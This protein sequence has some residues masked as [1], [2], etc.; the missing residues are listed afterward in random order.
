M[1]MLLGLIPLITSVMGV[2][3]TIAGALGSPL[4][5]SILLKAADIAERIFGT[6]DPGQIQ[7][8]IELDKVKLERFRIEL[9]EATKED[10]ALLADLQSARAQTLGLAQAQ[11]SI[12]WGAPIVSVLVTGGFFFVMAL[13]LFGFAVSFDEYVKNVLLI[14]IGV[15]SSG[16]NQTISYWLGS[17]R[18]SQGKDA[19][20]GAM[21]TTAQRETV[22]V[23]SIRSDGKMFK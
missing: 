12:A 10:V 19:L 16:F 15:L 18:G 22:P 5:G 9:E 14:L 11:S 21:A 13:F 4:A 8:Q 1:G 7:A 2:G 6:K 23:T 17:T 3:S 20:I